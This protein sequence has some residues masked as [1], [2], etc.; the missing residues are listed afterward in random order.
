ML[1]T[2]ANLQ[3]CVSQS[4][5]IWRLD[6]VRKPSVFKLRH[7]KKNT[8]F[9][10]WQSSTSGAGNTPYAPSNM[11]S[12]WNTLQKTM[13]I[14]LKPLIAKGKQEENL[15]LHTV[16]C[17]ISTTKIGTILPVEEELGNGFS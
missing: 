3:H 15:T 4:K 5:H 6:L 10:Q 9:F 8:W 1:T 11:L 13:N 17:F 12:C 14:H 7:K 16:R 2:T